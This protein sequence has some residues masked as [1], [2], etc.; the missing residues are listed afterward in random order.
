MNE[1]VAIVEFSN[2]ITSVERE[3]NI[4]VPSVGIPGPAGATNISVLDD[5]DSSTLVNGSVLVYKTN[6]SKWTS[7]TLLDAQN[8]EAG[9][10]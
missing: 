7:T 10:F 4:S 6:T 1:I 8:I 9:E 2:N 3:R 5:V